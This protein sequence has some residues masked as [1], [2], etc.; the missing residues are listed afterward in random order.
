MMSIY[1]ITLHVQGNIICNGWMNSLNAGG[2]DKHAFTRPACL[3]SKPDPT[4]SDLY[5]FL[6]YSST[7]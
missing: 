7:T 4:Q 1:M 3:T 5:C 6:H 2:D